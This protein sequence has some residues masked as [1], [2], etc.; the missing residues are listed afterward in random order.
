MFERYTEKARNAIL[1]ARYEAGILGS[2][3]IEPEHL[4]LSL[5]KEDETL[6]HLLPEPVLRNEML[7][8]L[9][10]CD[11]HTQEPVDIPLS[12][13]AKRALAYSAEA[14]QP[15]IFCGG[16][17]RERPLSCSHAE[18]AGAAPAS[19]RGNHPN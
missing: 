15:R 10:R 11:R 2:P 19:F 8:L 14:A 1:L 17:N 13:P 5:L 6:L 3:V 9:Q 7:Q 4:L 18:G 12:N 16:T